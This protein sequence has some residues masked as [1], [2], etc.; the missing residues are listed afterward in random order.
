MRLVS[1]PGAFGADGAYV[2]MVEGDRCWAARIPIHEEFHVFADGT[3]L[4][5]TDHT[6]ALGR[7]TAFRLHYLLLRD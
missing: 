3:N 2:T 4:L 6:L 7:A 5:R 1:P